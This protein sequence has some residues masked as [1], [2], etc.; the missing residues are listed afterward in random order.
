[1][2]F[3]GL[4]IC[5]IACGIGGAGFDNAYFQRKYST[6]CNGRMDHSKAIM[7]V[8]GGP[9]NLF[10]AF[11]YTGYGYYGWSLAINANPKCNEVKY[12]G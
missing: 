12:H 6:Q 2:K 10:V 7:S 4:T 5:W 3:V 8:I 11:L 9:L 1:M